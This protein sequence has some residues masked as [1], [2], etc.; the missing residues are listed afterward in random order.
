MKSRINA[1]VQLN[2]MDVTSV[3]YFHFHHYW[4]LADA[5]QKTFQLGVALCAPR[6]NYGSENAYFPKHSR[7]LHERLSL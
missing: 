4:R 3:R 5:D 1:C 7:D 2:V 6:Y